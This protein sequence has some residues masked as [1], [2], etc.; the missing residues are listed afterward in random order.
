[1]KENCGLSTELR[2]VVIAGVVQIPVVRIQIRVLYSLHI[3][4]TQ[5]ITVHIIILIYVL[6]S[7]PSLYM[8]CIFFYC[9]EGCL[10]KSTF[11][12]KKHQ[13]I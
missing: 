7:N 5:Y 8:L 12:L 3:F 4:I 10:L 2:F 6:K 1:M 11:Y 9:V 13:P